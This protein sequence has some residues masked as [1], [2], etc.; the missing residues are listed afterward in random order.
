MPAWFMMKT[1]EGNRAFVNLDAVAAIADVAGMAVAITTQG[2]QIPLEVAFDTV[3][4][5]LSG[6]EESS[7]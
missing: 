2:V 1:D 3:V 7:P 6:D 4:A 5:D